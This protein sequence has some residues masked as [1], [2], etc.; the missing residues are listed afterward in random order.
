MLS[1]CRVSVSRLSAIPSPSLAFEDEEESASIEEFQ[2]PTPRLQNKSVA[3]N[4]SAARRGA[5]S[6]RGRVAQARSR[7]AA[8][9]ISAYS[10]NI[11]NELS[12]SQ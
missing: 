7:W 10:P 5:P 6:N 3:R 8:G 1:P 9:L 11:V 12:V 4:K 2:S